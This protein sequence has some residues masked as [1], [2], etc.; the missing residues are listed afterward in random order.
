M[1]PT[2][3][4]A[5]DRRTYNSLPES[6]TVRETKVRVTQPGF[7]TR[8]IVVVT[9]LLDP[10]RTTKEDLAS[11]YRA[12]WNNELDL[13]SLKSTLQMH[14]LRC[15]TP[16]LVRSEIWTHVLAYNLIRTIMAQA[17]TTHDL[18]PRCISFKGACQTLEAFQPVIELQA[19]Q[20]PLHRLDLYLDLLDAI[21]THQVADRPDRF[22]PRLK[23]Q[24]RDH[25]GWLTRPRAD[26]KR[27]MAKG[28]IKS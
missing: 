25:Y 12:R 3:I 21:A 17:A 27:E 1:K 16:G 22:E 20:G 24:R 10:R 13:R 18:L 8:S 7:R 2:S 11:L 6:I 9:S 26:V 4:R 14:Q 15:K 28:K 23:K 5:L 19:A